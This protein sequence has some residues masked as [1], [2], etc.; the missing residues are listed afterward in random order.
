MIH[1]QSHPVEICFDSNLI[2][3]QTAEICKYNT[4]DDNHYCG[5]NMCFN[6]FLIG[7]IIFIVD[8]WYLFD[9]IENG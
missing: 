8:A 7:G 6:A 9:L 5:V 2:N 3:R 1:G 4:G